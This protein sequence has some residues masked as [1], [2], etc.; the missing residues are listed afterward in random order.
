MHVG[1]HIARN[2]HT[3]AITKEQEVAVGVTRGVYNAKAGQLIALSQHP[4]HTIRRT[5][6]DSYPKT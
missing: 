1:E 2:G 5:S 6:P 3:V 4:R